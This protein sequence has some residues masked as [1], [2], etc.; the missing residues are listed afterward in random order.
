MDWFG[1][2]ED[3]LIDLLNWFSHVLSMFTSWINEVWGWIVS[4]LYTPFSDIFPSIPEL[5][6]ISDYIAHS[7]V[8]DWVYVFWWIANQVLVVSVILPVL[9]A[10]LALN[11]LAWL[12]RA[13]LLI[14]QAVPFAG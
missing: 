7:D 4:P 5:R 3:L 6:A 11:V 14:K 12:Y 13:W 8:I 9:S 1:W 2:L 10:I